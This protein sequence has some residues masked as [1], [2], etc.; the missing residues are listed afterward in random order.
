MGGSVYTSMSGFRKYGTNRL[1]T[2]QMLAL[3]KLL[4]ALGFT[5]WDL[6][7]VLDYKLNN[8]YAHVEDRKHFRERL[9]ECRDNTDVRLD[10]PGDGKLNVRILLTL[11]DAKNAKF[12]DM[13]LKK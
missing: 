7:M 10:I 13:V 5:F 4:E 2:M 9:K 8:L 6:G 3:A 1:G 11:K 12:E